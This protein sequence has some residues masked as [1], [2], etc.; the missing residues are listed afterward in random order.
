MTIKGLYVMEGYAYPDFKELEDRGLTH[1]FYADTFLLNDYSTCKN[2]IIRLLD[3]MADTDLTLHININAFKASDQSSFVDP[4]NINHR[5][6][7]KSRLVQLLL[8]IPKIEGISFDN[9]QWQSWNGYNDDEKNVILAEFAKE[10]ANA[11]HGVDSSKQFS[12]SVIWSSTT[13]PSTAKELDFVMPKIYSSKSSGIPLSKA[14]NTVLEEIGDKKMVIDL[15]TYDSAVNL[16][17][18]TISDIYD[19]ISTV[20]KIN[21]ANYS[22]YASPWIPYGLGFPSVDYAFTEININLNL[23]SKHKFIPE[24]SSRIMTITFLD[25]NDNPLSQDLLGT[26]VGKYKITDQSS[27][28]IIKDFT[29]FI[30]DNSIYELT[31]SSDENRIINPDV[32]QENHIITVSIVYGDGKKENEELSLTIQNLLGIN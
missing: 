22:L 17:P 4:N 20:I 25:Q 13:L 30:P 29:N 15:L 19:E 31:I 3:E 18:K 24:K 21:G 1:V 10:M 28:R 23:V 6:Q 32:S 14:I 11:I 9:F 16:T 2:N 26:I 7:L 27:G 8:D 5:N 12:A